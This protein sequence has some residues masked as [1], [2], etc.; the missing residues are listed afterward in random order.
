MSEVKSTCDLKYA[1]PFE[2]CRL[3][4]M[5]AVQPDLLRDAAQRLKIFGYIIAGL[6]ASVL[7]F[8]T[9]IPLFGGPRMG[10]PFGLIDIGI[11]LIVILA[12]AVSFLARSERLRPQQM[13]D[14]G[15]L[16]VIFLS[17]ST[18][19]IL[20]LGSGPLQIPSGYG[21]SEICVLIVFFP[22]IIPNSPWKILLTALIAAS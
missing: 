19:V 22:V 9:I 4:G 2:K 18:G 12:L 17:F 5:T 20:K 13:L 3:P 15:L 21:V 10:E 11:I 1:L 8:Y 16:F 6:S 14:L 7:T